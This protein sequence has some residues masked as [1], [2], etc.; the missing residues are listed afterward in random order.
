MRLTAV[1]L[2]ITIATFHL[3][4]RQDPVLVPGGL[5]DLLRQL[6]FNQVRDFLPD[7]IFHDLDALK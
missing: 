7:I 3:E 4:S 1:L 6:R 2:V 5:I